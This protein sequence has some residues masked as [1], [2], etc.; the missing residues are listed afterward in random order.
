M[1]FTEDRSGVDFEN[2][3]KFVDKFDVDLHTKVIDWSEMKDLALSFFKAQVP[4]MDAVQDHAIWASTFQYARENNFKYIN[5]NL[6][7]YL[8]SIF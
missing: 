4:T 2:L 8:K 7:L 3:I 1:E 6:L 5:Y